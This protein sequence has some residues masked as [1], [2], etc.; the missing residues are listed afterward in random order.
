MFL[1][2][3]KVFVFQYKFDLHQVKRDLISSIKDFAYEL[4]YKIPNDLSLRSIWDYQI[5]EKS[6]H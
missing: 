1:S 2:S 6:Q 5:L 3:A 4:T